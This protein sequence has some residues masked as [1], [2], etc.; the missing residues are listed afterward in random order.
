MPLMRINASMGTSHGP[1][2]RPCLH[3]GEGPLEMMLA[4][5]LRASRGPVVLMVHG[6]RFSPAHP[7]H[8]PHR[9]ILSLHDSHACWK[10]LSW[11]GALGLRPGGAGLGIA[12]G[13]AARG[14]IWSA[15]AGA[16]AAGSA[17]AEL[18]DLIADLAPERPVHLLA[19]SL[20]ARVMTRALP[21]MTRGRIARAVLLAGALYGSELEAAL[22]SPAGRQTQ[23]IN[24]S[25]GENDLYDRLME[26]FLPA[27]QRG[28]RAVGAGLDSDLARVVTLRLD[29]PDCRAALT[30]IGFPVAP[31]SARVCHWSSYLRPGAFPLYRAFLRH[32]QAL[33]L[34]VLRE[35]HCPPRAERASFGLGLLGG[36]RPAN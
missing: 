8:C 29:S 15:W 4:H 36:A 10:A 30:R 19:H 5:A 11:P 34:P 32:P 28:D 20:G 7:T 9:H 25:S 14:S 2:P 13:W 6:Y 31:P 12:F 27:P 17:L 1:L 24:A 26:T 16:E 3:E 22:A 23:V 21:R 35:A 18:V 33:Q